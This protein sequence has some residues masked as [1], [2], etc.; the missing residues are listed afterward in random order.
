MRE[1]VRALSLLCGFLSALA[2]AAPLPESQIPQALKPWK[3][4]VLYGHDERPCPPA[5]AGARLCSWPARLDLA[6]DARGGRFTLEAH[7]YAPGWIELPGDARLWPQDV[8]ADGEPAPTLL[9]DEAPALHLA[10]GAHRIVGNFT[11][12]RL[13]E[14]LR[15]PAETGSIALSV[16]GTAQ[17][18][19]A[20]DARSR[21]WL[22]RSE[23]AAAQ[24]NHLVLKVYRQV[25]DL[26]PLRLVTHIDVEASGEVREEVF[27]PV[28]PAGFIPLLLDGNLPAH[29]DGD[30]K[31][32]VQVR[33]G[34]WSLEVTARAS[35]K[36]ER[37]ER[38][39]LPAPW[40]QDEIW[41][42]LA[43]PELRVVEASGGAPDDPR[44]TQMP[45]SWRALPAYLLNP[46]AALRLEEKQR[47]LITPEPDQL[48]LQREIWLDGDGG[49][50]TVQ[51]R[52]E[53][54]LNSRW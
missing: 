6:V 48:H 41:S 3:D 36:V 8:S 4:W 27:G 7:L 10:P 43:H 33:P 45:E 9:R 52:L 23:A 34:L 11:W 19:P 14:S 2:A 16:N 20:R 53:G 29:L 54:R 35:A 38:P 49:G 44:Q 50:Y 13:P 5:A 32:H 47:G 12:T 1:A 25:E 28:Y 30:G 15:V 22:G 46:G 39:A 40:P 24:S 37:I 26:I 31:L 21:L 42:F 51:D 17:P 18:H